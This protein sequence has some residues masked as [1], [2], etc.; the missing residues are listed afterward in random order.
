MNE[1]T[2]LLA[3]LKRHRPTREKPRHDIIDGW[4]VRFAQEQPD[5]DFFFSILADRWNGPYPTFDAAV[6]AAT[7]AIAFQRRP[8]EPW[9]MAPAG[10]CAC[11]L[12]DIRF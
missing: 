9:C 8:H 3:F 10:V 5:C 6:E 12:D 11:D 4:S 2:Q 1:I 7:R